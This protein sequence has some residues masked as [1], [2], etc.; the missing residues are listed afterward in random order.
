MNRKKYTLQPNFSLLNQFVGRRNELGRI[1]K[2]LS[3]N[4]VICVTGIKGVGKSSLVLQSL[5]KSKFLWIDYSIKIDEISFV[6][7]LQEAMKKLDDGLSSNLQDLIQSIEVQRVVLVLDNFDCLNVELQSHCLRLFQSIFYHS[8]LIICNYKVL[9]SDTY[10]GLT[11]RLSC[12]SDKDSAEL[13]K[14][15]FSLHTSKKVDKREV[16]RLSY[17]LC[18]HPLLI[19]EIMKSKFAK[20]NIH[21]L[22]EAEGFSHQVYHLV[23]KELFQDLNE[24]QINFIQFL[25]TLDTIVQADDSAISNTEVQTLLDLHILELC[26]N[27]QSIRMLK[28]VCK[29]CL[30]NLQDKDLI[31][32]H[33]RAFYFAISVTY[34][35]YKTVFNHSKQ[36]SLCTELID[37]SLDQ[38]SNKAVIGEDY[39]VIGESYI[40]ELLQLDLDYKRD[41]LLFFK[42]ESNI[43]ILNT[44]V[45][46][47]VVEKINDPHIKRMCQARLKSA[48][49]QK[50]LAKSELLE[51]LNYETSDDYKVILYFDLCYVL[52]HIKEFDLS[53]TKL[54]ELQL[55][56]QG[57]SQ[58]AKNHCLTILATIKYNQQRF[59]ESLDLCFAIEEFHLRSKN[60]FALGETQFYII[61]NYM[62]LEDYNKALQYSEKYKLVLR[63]LKDGLSW[64][65][66]HSRLSII[67][68][69]LDKHGLS[70]KECVKAYDLAKKHNWVVL[71][72]IEARRLATLEMSNRN[73]TLALELAMESC[74]SSASVNHTFENC[75]SRYTL[76]AIYIIMDDKRVDSELLNLQELID[77]NPKN[78]RVHL[79]YHLLL[80]YKY[81][82]SELQDQANYQ[83]AIYKSNFSK[84]DLVDQKFTQNQIYWFEKIL[85][86]RCQYNVMLNNELSKV[87]NVIELDSHLAK[88][89]LYQMFS[90]EEK[91]YVNGSL[92][93][94]ENSPIQRQILMCFIES[95]TKVW[96]Q[97]ELIYKIWG[98]D[99]PLDKDRTHLRVQIHKLKS[100][101]NIQFFI[102]P[103]SGTYLFNSE[104][105]HCF[106]F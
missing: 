9:N 91:L 22:N 68:E 97:N 42:C 93:D 87:S 26:E 19:H 16:Q 7:S 15:S 70:Q 105:S 41:Q 101:L 48:L 4:N 30:S 79:I 45:A 13:I 64:Y 47:Q 3:S 73:V 103:Q 32:F 25:A 84:L 44:D 99:F 76:I 35:P 12:L 78:Q 55:L 100:T 28:I 23:L 14:S 51:C 80:F 1:R 43:T 77:N 88:K 52:I 104:V 63:E 102:R 61:C 40:D 98:K 62:G 69:K 90:F 81:E 46:Q 65:F 53:E 31:S 54:S 21:K 56:L 24:T 37:Y 5:K 66:Y 85:S 49:G 92:L 89:H 95:S 38:I 2:S 74:L 18:G 20:P 94:F 59:Q 17:E 29:G 11:F 86:N 10:D 82:S 96:T 50:E 83:L 36:S 39:F 106:I 75:L 58:E 72:A 57:S 27:D 67:Y 34:I 8:K 33:K 60:T 6:E 71:L